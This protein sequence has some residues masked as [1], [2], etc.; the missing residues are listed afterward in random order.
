MGEPSAFESATDG[1]RAASD[2]FAVVRSSGIRPYR[3]YRFDDLIEQ[4]VFALPCRKRK[5]RNTRFHAKRAARIGT[6]W[7]YRPVHPHPDRS[8]HRI[9]IS[10]PPFSP[11]FLS[12][13]TIKKAGPVFNPVRTPM[14]R[15][16]RRPCAPSCSSHRPPNRQPCLRGQEVCV[17][18]GSFTACSDSSSVPFCP[19][20]S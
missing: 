3:F 8:T 7:R 15:K 16:A 12:G 14:Q 19:A 6:R 11:N 4:F 5:H 17:I 18:K 13:T 1:T 20:K 9:C 2:E 10:S